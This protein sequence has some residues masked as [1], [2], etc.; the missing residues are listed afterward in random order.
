MP[1]VA[2][3]LELARGGGWQ[4]RPATRVLR[5]GYGECRDKANLLRALLRESG[6]TAWLV[7]ARASCPQLVDERWPAPSC[8]NHCIV[9]VRAPWALNEPACVVD[10]RLGPL[11]LFDPTDP[12]TMPGEIPGGLQGGLA[13]L[14]A[15]DSSA[16]VRVPDSGPGGNRLRREVVGE[17]GADG[18]IH[19]SLEDRASGQ[20]AASGRSLRSALSADEYRA[21][22]ERWLSNSVNGARLTGLQSWDEPDS[23][24]FRV[25]M[26]FE[27]PRYATP[28][29][30]RLLTFPP[31]VAGRMEG[32]RLDDSSR[33]N[34]VQ[35]EPET[36]E[37]RTVLRLPAGF[38]VDEFP[39]SDSIETS[40]G[41]YYFHCSTQGDT[42]QLRRGLTL[43]R[44]D[45]PRERFPEVLDFF[46]RARALEQ[47]SVVLV[48]SPVR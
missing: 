30:D 26:S 7:S 27:A 6:I 41:A 35:L 28:V 15:G 13:L 8:F 11:L 17:I 48:R 40:F 9:A 18:S 34:P 24:S 38:G 1:Y 29:G 42:L 10:P 39:R 14:I 21:M 16:L 37:E 20:A 46:R 25:A 32:L 19:A 12:A 45:L 22:M 44:S 47:S 23:G 36:R 31:A 5:Q 33:R 2:L 3:E 4:P 43:R